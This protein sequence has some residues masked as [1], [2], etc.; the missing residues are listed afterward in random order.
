MSF[1]LDGDR[2]SVTKQ[3]RIELEKLRLMEEILVAL[4]GDKKD[5]HASNVRREPTVDNE[6]SSR[7][8]RNSKRLGNDSTD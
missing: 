2:V 1:L 7:G 4:K 5:A 3:D 8:R 6:R